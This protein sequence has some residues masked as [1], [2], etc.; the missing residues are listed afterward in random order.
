MIDKITIKNYRGH[1]DLEISPLARINL[2]SGRNGVGK[3]AL[4]EALWLLQGRRNPLVIVNSN[5]LRGVSAHPLTT[6]A[7]DDSKPI[8]IIGTEGRRKLTLTI[9]RGGSS[10]VGSV[11]SSGKN[12]QEDYDP[13]ELDSG[14]SD[15]AQSSES[16]IR[17]TYKEGNKNPVSRL[18]PIARTQT[19]FEAIVEGATGSGGLPSG[20]LV[21]PQIGVTKD[22]IERFST[23]VREGQKQSIID[24]MKIIEPRLVALEI[25]S[26]GVPSIWCSLEPERKLLR[27]E[28]VG[29]GLAH[30]MYMLSSIYVARG[31]MVAF[32]E[33]ENGFHH[34]AMRDVWMVVG[35]LAESLDV[36]IFATTHSRE[37]LAAAFE[38][39]SERLE[40][41]NLVIHHLFREGD[42]T[43]SEPYQGQKLEAV[44]EA[45][46]EVR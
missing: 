10:L 28:S 29:Q 3:T 27:L 45:G 17:M 4:L 23:I 12:P 22:L 30:F 15:S 21:R 33:V 25:L 26:E 20:V 19:G 35:Q 14:Q 16:E 1:R 18:I 32:D 5:I 24:S 43:K 9:E 31:G 8:T 44:L 7:Q 39:Q 34:S 38:A 36:Q 40:S 37:C 41:D 6:L 46:F 42:V 2:F 11:D 13:N